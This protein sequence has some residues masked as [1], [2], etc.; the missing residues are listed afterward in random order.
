MVEDTLQWALKRWWE[1][2]GSLSGRPVVVLQT[3][4]KT[5]RNEAVLAG[6][7][8]PA[9]SSWAPMGQIFNRRFRFLPY[10]PKA[11]KICFVMKMK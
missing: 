5:H 8:I 6:D 11:Q 3:S 7:P 1:E 2:R 4:L 9:T 10:E